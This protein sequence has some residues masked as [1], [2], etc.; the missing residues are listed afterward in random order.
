MIKTELA[1]EY[2]LL[3]LQ[4]LKYLITSFFLSSESNHF[5][6]RLVKKIATPL[7]RLKIRTISFFKIS[8]DRWVFSKAQKMVD[9]SRESRVSGSCSKGFLYSP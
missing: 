8:I 9:Q 3:V 7:D 6:V 2:Q 1:L 5:F 4:L